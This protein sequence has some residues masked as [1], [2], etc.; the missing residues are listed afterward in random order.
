MAITNNSTANEMAATATAILQTGAGTRQDLAV[1]GDGH[2]RCMWG[3]QPKI[4][5]TY[6][7]T[8]WGRPVIDERAIFEKL[9][10]EGF[11]AGLSWLTILKKREAFRERF[12][13]F[14]PEVLAGWGEAEVA[15]A[16]ADSNIVRNRAKIEATLGNA[17]AAIQLW[18]A[19]DSLAELLWSAGDEPEHVAPVS[20]LDASAVPLGATALSK[21]LKKRGFRFVGPTTVHSTMQSLGVANDHLLGCWVRDVCETER[22][23]A[24]Q[25]LSDSSG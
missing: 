10:L 12:Q 11:Q 5:R 20:M 19:G 24:R 17:R 2:A 3:V 6:H 25:G 7:D 14:D 9:C 22:D 21:I 18:A 1:G 16:L 8:E 13:G 15:D 23:E 4:Y